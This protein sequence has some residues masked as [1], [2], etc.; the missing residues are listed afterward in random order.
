MPGPSTERL[1]LKEH[2][3]HACLYGTPNARL[4]QSHSAISLL[5]RHIK[6][7]IVPDDPIRSSL[8][9]CRSPPDTLRHKAIA[10]LL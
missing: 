8:A 10:F 3:R 6:N 9:Q 7:P 5:S 4:R 2:A 1:K